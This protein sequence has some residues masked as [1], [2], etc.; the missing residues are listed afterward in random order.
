MT[1][2]SI[3][4]LLL[5][6]FGGNPYHAIAREASNGDLYYSPIEIPLEVESL[7]SHLEGESILG[8]YQV[9]QG[10]NVVKFIGWDV[11]SKDPK[12]A[13]EQ[14][15][16]ILRHLQ[17][18]PHVVEYSGRKGYHVLIFL[19]EPMPATEA[20]RIVDW[21]REK[22]GLSVSGESHVEAFPKQDRLTKNKPKGNLLKIPLGLH[23]RTHNRSIFVDP[24]NGWE[25]GTPCNP[26]EM[27]T[28]RASTEDLYSIVS[29]TGA[30]A[31]IQ[32]VQLVSEYWTDGKRHDLSLYLSGFLA[33]EGWGVDQAKKLL[34]DICKSTGDTE[35][36]NR[37]QTVENTF[38]KY[39]EG[40]GV[41]G[42]QGLG[43][44]LPVTAMMK[45]TE[46]VSLIR[47][48][49]T[50]TQIDD[51]RYT[52]GRPTLESARLASNTIWSI[53]NDEGCRIF[54][55]EKN[56]AYWYDAS[57]HTVV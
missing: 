34:T 49:D 28:N 42:R 4:E 5:E 37:V 12:I 57:D 45:L 36:Y 47:S 50:V 46:L 3:E 39:K 55:T 32:L 22:E 35:E 48:P 38:S 56:V 29:A 13:R 41:R 24:S 54:Q 2:K 30:P 14:T 40:K 44:I 18:I 9:L 20:K 7:H 25:S 27:L 21:V 8:S 16:L 1:D 43:E 6:I 31:D 23:P 26:Y 52:K 53:L 15:L 10:S 51:I 11:D 19:K 17:D 33:H